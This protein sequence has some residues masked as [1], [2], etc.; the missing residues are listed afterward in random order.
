VR[1]IV[2][3]SNGLFGKTVAKWGTDEQRCSLLPPL[4]TGDGLG[5][6]ALTEPGAARCSRT[7]HARRTNGDEWALTGSKVFIT[8]ACGPTRRLRARS[9]PGPKGIS[10]FLVPTGSAGFE[11]GR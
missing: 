4:A 5:C 7:D 6:Y 11:R 3:V 2:S 9:G 1:G 8:L 10:A